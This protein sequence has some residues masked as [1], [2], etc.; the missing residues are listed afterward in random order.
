MSQAERRFLRALRSAGPH[1]LPRSRVRPGCKPV[2]QELLTCQAVRWC[3]AGRGQV[4]QI[5]H[6]EAFD[7]VV[8]RRF[9]LGLDEPTIPITDRSSA[10]LAAGDA[11]QIAR[12]ACQGIFVRS[13]RPG[14]TVRSADGEASVPVADLTRAAGGAALLLDDEHAWRFAGTVAVIENAEAFWRHDRVLD[15]DLAIYTAGRMSSHRLLAWLA[16]QPMSECSYLHWGDYDPVGTLEYLRLREA[17]PERVRM[18][19]PDELEKLVARYGKRGLLIDQ[20]DELHRLRHFADDS[21]VAQLIDVWDRHQR[22]L[23]QELLLSV[24]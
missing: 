14:A 20:A 7:A 17:C 11:K 19:I 13:T 10:V 5:I 16:S 23:E 9:P 22:G 21:A 3:P 4:L 2:V 18:H 8:E 6:Q 15:V 12:G 1:G 24:A